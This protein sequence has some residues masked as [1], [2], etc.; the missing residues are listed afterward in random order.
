MPC[1]IQ[2][3]KRNKQLNA[4]RLKRV[5]AVTDP[6][7]GCHPNRAADE[8]S[9]GTPGRARLTGKAVSVNGVQVGWACAI[10]ASPKS[11][12]AAEVP[13]ASVRTVFQNVQRGRYVPVQ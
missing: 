3:H 13:Q 2:R 1:G 12:N 7:S 4:I 9:M 10:R 6:T 11:S 8:G 5:R